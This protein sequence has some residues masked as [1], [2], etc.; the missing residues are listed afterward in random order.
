[1][2][3]S[4]KCGCGELIKEGNRYING[5]N[6]R[7]SNNSNWK[8]SRRYERTYA[9]NHPKSWSNGCVYTHIL[10]AE[11]ALGKPLPPDAEIHHVKGNTNNPGNLV[12]CQNR[13]YHWLLHQRQRA[14]DACGHAN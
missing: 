5:H 1:M 4:C 11:K 3:N 9:P 2:Q 8:G 12:I 14:Y 13:T 6:G 10:I 7:G